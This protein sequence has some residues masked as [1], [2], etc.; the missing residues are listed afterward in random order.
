MYGRADHFGLPER[1]A[2]RRDPGRGVPRPT[3]GDIIARR[4]RI[5]TMAVLSHPIHQIGANLTAV[6]HRPNS[7]GLSQDQIQ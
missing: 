5:G 1:S 2:P 6:A 3:A 7:D 4:T